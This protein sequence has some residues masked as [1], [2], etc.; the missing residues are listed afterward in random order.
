MVSLA[1]VRQS[2]GLT[3]DAMAAKVAAITGNT[4]T[5]ASLSA[6]EKGHRGASAETL[7][8]IE[9]ALS[10]KAGSVAVDYTPTHARRPLKAVG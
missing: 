6:I 4:F 8:A 10:L 3:Q 7:A 2:H 9:L 5:N 1:A